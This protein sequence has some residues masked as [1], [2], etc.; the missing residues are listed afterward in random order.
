MAWMAVPLKIIIC[1][2]S[3]LILGLVIFT[4][5]LFPEEVDPYV[6]FQRSLIN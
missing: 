4:S 5:P 1:F 6:E 2:F 3:V